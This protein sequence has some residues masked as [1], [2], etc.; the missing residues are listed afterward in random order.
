MF[1]LLIQL[2]LAILPVLSPVLVAGAKKVVTIPNPVKPILNAVLGAGVAYATG[3]DPA[4]GVL[5]A[6]VGKSVRDALDVP[7]A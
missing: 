1:A 4:L 6:H 2:A 5:A 3:N 7:E